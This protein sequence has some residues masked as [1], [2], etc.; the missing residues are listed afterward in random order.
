ME[1]PTQIN[2]KKA[3]IDLVKV[4]ET[5]S[6][7]GKIDFCGEYIPYQIVRKDE[8]FIKK[9]EKAKKLINH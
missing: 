2:Y 8:T 6:E 7:I 9:F 1:S 5:H 3:L 4:I